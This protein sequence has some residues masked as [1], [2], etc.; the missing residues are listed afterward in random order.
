MK[1]LIKWAQFFPQ[2]TSAGAELIKNEEKNIQYQIVFGYY[3]LSPQ[4][5]KVNILFCMTRE[6]LKS[7]KW[8]RRTD[9]T[10]DEKEEEKSKI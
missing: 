2:L 5:I 7:M 9:C 3:F 4:S 10:K 6:V 8:S 1:Y